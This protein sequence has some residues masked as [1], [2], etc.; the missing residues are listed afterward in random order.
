MKKTNQ[1]QGPETPLLEDY[2]AKRDFSKTS[3]PPGIDDLKLRVG[4]ILSFKNTMHV[5]CISTCVSNGTGCW[6]CGQYQK[7]YPRLPVEKHL[8][9]AVED[10]PLDYGHF[11]G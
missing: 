7:E 6:K 8:A 9:V 2:H 4:I 1:E 3:E 11:E 10:H 5:A